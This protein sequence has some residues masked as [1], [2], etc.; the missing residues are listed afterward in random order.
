VLKLRYALLW[1][2][3]AW[4]GV[5]LALIL[6]LWPGGAP[7]PFHLWDKLEHAIGYL[8]L[9]LWF[10]GL[11]PKARYPQI[12]L[13]ALLLG[14]GIELLQAPAPTRSMELGDAAADAVG[15]GLAWLLAW[16]GMGG[17]ASRIERWIGPAT[18]SSG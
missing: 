4:I 6:S 18:A 9:T 11:Y 17:W 3:I 7:L 5:A 15:I 12:A 2:G 1:A 16:T 8:I 13:G 14:I 10:M